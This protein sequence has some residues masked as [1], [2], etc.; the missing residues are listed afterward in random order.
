LTTLPSWKADM[1]ERLDPA[2]FEA[3]VE[4][5][6]A[7]DIGSGDLTTR[8][9]IDPVR[10]ASARLIAR[11]EMIVAGL[12]VVRHI[13]RRLDADCHFPF[14]RD[15]G[16]RLDP[17]SEILVVMGSAAGLLQ[18]ERTALNFLQR[19][20]G[21]ATLTHQYAEAVQGT[22]TR[23]VDTRKTTPGLR[24]LEKYAV[25]CGGGHNHRTGLFD[26]VLIKENHI[27]A[28]GSIASAV[29]ACQAEVSHLIQVEVEVTDLA[30]LDEALQAGAAVIMLD[31]FGL[32]DIRTAV[33]RT[34][35][36]ARLE[37]SG[38]VTLERIRGLAETGVDLISVGRMTHSA[39]AVDISMLFE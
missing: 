33:K 8:A 25:R 18:A 3:I 10:P 35:G 16:D 38:N 19:L 1:N 28:A 4:F 9:C 23:V 34:S 36:N 27:R 15:D 17:D 5:A 30:E 26:G 13:F 6:L 20:S 37:V 12:D 24:T 22:N 29:K 32:D 2:A 7:E 14:A 39:R 21:V 11:E 31:N